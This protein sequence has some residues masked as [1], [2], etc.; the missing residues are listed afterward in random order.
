MHALW[1]RLVRLPRARSC[2]CT[3][4]SI[5]GTLAG[6][7]AAAWAAGGVPRKLRVQVDTAEDGNTQGPRDHIRQLERKGVAVAGAERLGHLPNLFHEPAERP[8]D[9]SR[10]VAR[11]KR[12]G[13]LVLQHA[14]VHEHI[15]RRG[16]SEG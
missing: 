16:R 1:C 6:Q 12:D 8:I 7:A 4:S 10:T 14:D 15:T 5:D 3:A 11:A 2:R 9:A 13:D